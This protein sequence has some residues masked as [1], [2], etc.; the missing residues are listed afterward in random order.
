MIS[1]EVK[2][3]CSIS[4]VGRVEVPQTVLSLF[5]LDQHFIC[6][7]MNMS[8]S[9]SFSGAIFAV[10]DGHGEMAGIWGEGE[11]GGS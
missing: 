1:E 8:I 9:L 5:D 6:R 2:A 4:Q 10:V 3:S 11:V 7:I